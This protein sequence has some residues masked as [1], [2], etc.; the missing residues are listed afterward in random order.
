MRKILIDVLIL[1]DK[2]NKTI[3]TDFHIYETVMK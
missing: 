1:E 2:K 3:V